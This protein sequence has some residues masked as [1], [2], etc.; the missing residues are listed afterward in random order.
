MGSFD[1]GGNNPGHRLIDI[2]DVHQGARNHHVD[3]PG[4]RGGKRP[5]DD[6]QRVGVHQVALVGGA[7]DVGKLRAV[8]GRPEKNGRQP[9]DQPGFAVTAHHVQ[10]A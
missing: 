5:L 4:F 3:D 9:F 1:D 6:G 8:S 10:A 2:D 7:Q